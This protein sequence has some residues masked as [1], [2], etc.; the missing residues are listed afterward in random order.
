MPEKG[1]RRGRLEQSFERL[2]RRKD[3]F[4][5]IVV[6]AVNQHYAIGLQRAAG[7]FLEEFEVLFAQLFAR[8]VRRGAR[9]GIEIIRAHQT[10]GGFVVVAADGED[11]ERPD[12]VGDFV[13]VWAVADDVTQTDGAVPASLY[14]PESS[15][16]SFGIRMNI[17]QNQQPHSRGLRR[18]GPIIDEAARSCT[19][20]GLAAARGPRSPFPF[21]GEMATNGMPEGIV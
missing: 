17:A 20:G 1:H 21:G 7:K 2:P 18:Q 5:L 9:H 8:P 16:K 4:V 3:V 19:T 10:C 14:G 11:V 13:G 6:G 15:V 12:P